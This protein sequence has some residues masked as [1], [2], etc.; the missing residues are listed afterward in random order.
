MATD[1]L[2]LSADTLR[3]VGDARHELSARLAVWGCG[4]VSDSLVVFSELVTNAVVH[5]GGARRIVVVHEGRTLRFEV[6]DDTHSIPA[7]R[8]SDRAPGGFGLRIVAQ[9]SD[10]WG[11]EQSATGKVVWSNLDCSDGDQA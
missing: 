10:S 11:F 4:R 8:G 7:V 5:A 1:I 2:T 6:H 9:L 3:R